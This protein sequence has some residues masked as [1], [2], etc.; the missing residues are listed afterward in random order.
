MIASYIAMNRKSDS[1]LLL[2]KR[3]VKRDVLAMFLCERCRKTYCQCIVFK[4]RSK[5]SQCT[6][7]HKLCD[8]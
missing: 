4:N 3:I 2:V 6:Q 7:N 8:L 5:Y 1:R